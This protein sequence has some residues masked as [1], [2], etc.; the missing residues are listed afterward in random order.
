MIRFVF[1]VGL[2][3]ASAG[4]AAHHGRHITLDCGSASKRSACGLTNPLFVVDG[5]ILDDPA[6]VQLLDPKRITVIEVLGGPEAVERFGQRGAN[7][8]VLITRSGPRP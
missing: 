4:C 1:A 7:G 5:H 3:L 8:V 2:V 6:E